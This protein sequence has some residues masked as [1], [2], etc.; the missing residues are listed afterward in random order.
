MKENKMDEQKETSAI[1]DVI[2]NGKK[3]YLS[4]WKWVTANIILIVCAALGVWL[5]G[6]EKHFLYSLLKGFIVSVAVTLN[7]TLDLY[8]FTRIDFTRTFLMGKNGRTDTNNEYLFSGLTFSAIIIKNAII[9]G[10]VWLGIYF[11]QVGGIQ[12]Q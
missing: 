4:T 3:I 9:Y 10:L 11:V 7:A 6:F 8:A 2:E 1:E 12:G 5:L